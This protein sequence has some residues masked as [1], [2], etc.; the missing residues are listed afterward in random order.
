ML[1]ADADT[2]WYLNENYL[3]AGDGSAP[4]DLTGFTNIELLGGAGNN[5]IEIIKWS[6]NV[7]IDGRTGSDTI[8][9]HS[10]SGASV[11]INDT[12]ATDEI[13]VL[14]KDVPQ[15]FKIDASTVDIY[16][17]GVD[18]FG[19]ANRLL[20]LTYNPGITATAGTLLV[21][22][23]SEQDTFI[24]NDS[25]TVS[26][27]LDG[28]GGADNYRLIE[29]AP[30]TITLITESGTDDH[31]DLL[32]V[33]SDY[34][35]DNEQPTYNASDSTLRFG[36][37]IESVEFKSST[38]ILNLTGSDTFEVRS[39]SVL[40]NGIVTY[41][42]GV[43]DLT[44]TTIG[45]GNTINIVNYP[46]AL[47]KFT[48][49]ATNGEND[50]LLGPAQRDNT[51]VIDAANAGTLNGTPMLQFY[52]TENLSGGE[53]T[54]T[55]QFMDASEI[56]GIIN[57]GG[58]SSDDVTYA[59]TSNAQV[60]DLSSNRFI[61]LEVITGSPQLDTLQGYNEQTHWLINGLN[62]GH[63]NSIAFSEI[64]NIT[65][66][67]EDD[68]F[69]V[70]NQAKLNGQ[71]DGSSGNNTL[72]VLGT[73]ASDIVH[74]SESQ[75]TMNSI[76]NSFIRI[77]TVKIETVGDSDNVTVTA[78]ASE[79][80]KTVQI[81]T[82]DDDD[83]IV[84][85]MANVTDT[86]FHIDGGNSDTGDQLTIVG[87][88]AEDVA[89]VTEKS[90][91]F[92][93]SS[94]MMN[95]IEHLT[96]ES[97][98][99]NDRISVTNPTVS[100]DIILNGGAEDDQFEVTYPVT[101]NSL[102]VIGGTGNQNELTVTTSQGADILTME[103]T[104]I[105]V[106]NNTSTT[107]SLIARASVSTLG[108]EDNITIVGTILGETYFA[109][110]NDAD[111]IE[112]SGTHGRVTVEAEDGADRVHI[113]AT[114]ALLLVDLGRGDDQLNVG[115]AIDGSH[116]RLDNIR[117]LVSVNGSEDFD[118][119][120][121]NASDQTSQLV[122]QMDAETITGLSMDRGI[123][124]Q[125]SEEI[126]IAF[127]SY[128]DDFEIITTPPNLQ[129]NLETGH[130]EDGVTVRAING[131]TKIETSSGSDTV[132]VRPVSEIAVLTTNEIPRISSP[133]NHRLTIDGG[134]ESTT[135]DSFFYSWDFASSELGVLSSTELTGLQM[136]GGIGYAG[137]DLVD[138][139]LNYVSDYEFTIESTHAG[140][141]NLSTGAGGDL[142]HV[143]ATSGA[144]LVDTGND[145]DTINVAAG[146]LDTI[147]GHLTV[148]TGSGSNDVATLDDAGTNLLFDYR[149][150]PNLTTSTKSAKAAP[151][152]PAR[153]FAGI[154]YDDGLEL[155]QLA[156]S[157]AAN[158]FSV[159]PSPD[160]V[161][162]IDGNDPTAGVCTLGGGD[163]L[164]LDLA[165]L[166]PDYPENVTG[167][168]IT[169]TEVVDGR[170][171]KGFWSFDSQHMDVL[172]ANMEGFNLLDKLS[173]SDDLGNQSDANVDI[174]SASSNQPYHDLV[175]NFRADRIQLVSLGSFGSATGRPAA[176]IGAAAADANVDGRVSMLDALHIINHI[177]RNPGTSLPY[178]GS[179]DVNRDETVTILDALMILN[180]VLRLDG[181][182]PVVGGVRTNGRRP[183]L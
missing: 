16:P 79:L 164:A 179:L 40:L 143:L 171:V 83:S 100:G 114:T 71:L 41:L 52:G 156:G 51:W 93:E 161:F 182:K 120:N 24:V 142:V 177:Y 11:T 88:A 72:L 105:S 129:L 180:Y 109:L 181:R 154:S 155:L 33:Y 168:Q 94:S 96:I 97:H 104:Q 135:T 48:I 174:F 130:G 87:T 31:T 172:F 98:G 36:S 102:H 117:G 57:G 4:F 85:E 169:F 42:E 126:N 121:I 92:A 113:T 107:H 65:G 17:Q 78:Q 160:T 89:I 74:L 6:G 69:T 12:G 90:I 103:Q 133:I 178:Q 25:S 47:T 138:L 99:G 60:I 173:L 22:G 27:V 37:N 23:G 55:F 28:K 56:T 81:T 140:L 49:N 39:D 14:G 141:T 162:E 111:Q 151:G 54:D 91:Q 1:V 21:T 44:L 176:F 148:Q 84:I 116:N 77:Q 15:Q 7:T 153:A 34:M 10:D 68:H 38:P 32:T 63:I 118:T 64:E 157:Q 2:D 66:G 149:V 158:L 152:T 61:N 26:L 76:T 82:G 75:I 132:V 125:S 150:T 80:P 144:T 29:R 139:S 30:E 159:R 146:D 108:G 50:H 62:S 123:E 59:A 5:R 170:Q 58:G 127:G 136:P 101:S 165:P 137:L 20:G 35:G 19:S 45:N 18:A 167:E 86:A 67:T 119:I 175:T 147:S 110:G 183:E 128:D 9:V 122:G 73:E 3:L 145:S 112:I 106:L 134:N 95:S 70:E 43:T 53:L 13:Q 8:I 163:S 115:Y 166:P 46:E 131:P 124:Y